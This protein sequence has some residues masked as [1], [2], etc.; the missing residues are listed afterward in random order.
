MI[1]K[2]TEKDLAPIIEIEQISFKPPWPEILFRSIVKDPGFVLYEKN[3][4]V[5]GYAAVIVIDNYGHLVN[6]A[7]HPEHRRKGIG[8]ELLK[9]C[10]DYAKE[11][12]AGYITLEVRTRN[13]EARKF[14]SKH[15]FRVIG[16]VP[17]YYKDDNAYIMEKKLH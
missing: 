14:Y 9:W 8:S 6:I 3:G 1:R 17:D 4:N 5:L 2:V 12:G 15:G 10:M 7:V 16:I 11:N 13:L